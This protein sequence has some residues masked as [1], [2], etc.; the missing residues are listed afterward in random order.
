MQKRAGMDDL[1]MPRRTGARILGMIKF[2]LG[3]SC[4]IYVP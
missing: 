4:P 1:G 3:F 2:E